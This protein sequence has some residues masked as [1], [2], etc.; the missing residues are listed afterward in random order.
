MHPITADTIRRILDLG[1]LPAALTDYQALAHGARE[2]E[3]AA[4]LL[5][6]YQELARAF[7]EGRIDD[8]EKSRRE[9]ALKDALLAA[10]DKSPNSAAPVATLPADA[11]PAYLKIRH[12]FKAEPIADNGFLVTISVTLRNKGKRLLPLV[13]GNVRVSRLYPLVDPWQQKIREQLAGGKQTYF[14]L[15]PHL[16]TLWLRSF[17]DRKIS[18]A[19][20]EREQL[21]FRRIVAG[22]IRGI[23]IQTAVYDPSEEQQLMAWKH[24]TFH[25]FKH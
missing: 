15:A 10:L 17:D 8:L 21:V 16:T 6:R 20:G 14:D 5:R 23:E 19:P 11:T 22:Y 12:R 3:H 25:F 1:E 9:E 4:E 7:N 18:L 24:T 2:A 13:S